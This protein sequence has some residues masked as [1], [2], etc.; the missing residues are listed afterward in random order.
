MTFQRAC[1]AEDVLADE[2]LDRLIA[3]STPL[4]DVPAL[5][6]EL[7]RAAPWDPPQRV[8]AAAL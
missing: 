8:L 4:E 2:A 1:A 7:A 6:A 5:Y 3:P